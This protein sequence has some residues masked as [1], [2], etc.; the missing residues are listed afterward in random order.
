[1][2][3]K[4]NI[5][6]TGATGNLGSQLLKLFLDNHKNNNIFLLIRGKNKIEAEGRVLG[7]F[8][9]F[10]NI[11]FLCNLNNFG[12]II[13]TVFRVSILI[14]RIPNRSITPMSI[15]VEI[16]KNPAISASDKEDTKETRKMVRMLV[17]SQSIF[18]GL[19]DFDSGTNFIIK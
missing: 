16:E 13:G 17:S 5:L 2:I 9:R 4:N 8:K 18:L 10:F 12:S 11:N 6:L 14:N 15:S 7:L 19:S 1:M 3:K